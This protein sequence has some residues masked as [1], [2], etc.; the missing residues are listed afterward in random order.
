MLMSLLALASC[1]STQ[2]T[3][4][5]RYKRNVVQYRVPVIIISVDG[6]STTNALKYVDPGKHVL[7]LR[8]SRVASPNNSPKTVDFEVAPCTGYVLAAQHENPTSSR[9]ELVIDRTFPL[10]KCQW[11]E[12]AVQ[13]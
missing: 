2:S 11:N 7:K 10:P 9:W 13:K 6:K 4:D 5:G 3:L 8:S 1:A 12:Q